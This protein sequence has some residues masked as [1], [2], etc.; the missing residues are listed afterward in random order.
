MILLSA[1]IIT[2]EV[3]TFFPLV[4]KSVYWLEDRLSR[5]YDTHIAKMCKYLPTTDR[6]GELPPKAGCMC[7]IRHMEEGLPVFE[8]EFYP[9]LVQGEPINTCISSKNLSPLSILGKLT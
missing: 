3:T 4:L 1:V 5:R 8:R 6:Y 7:G 2:F 9:L